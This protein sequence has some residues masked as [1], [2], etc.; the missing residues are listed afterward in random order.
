MV[1]RKKTAK[2][3][4]PKKLYFQDYGG[5]AY[6]YSSLQQAKNEARRTINQLDEVV[7]YEGKPILRLKLAVQEEKL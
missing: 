1:A 5:E 4:T 2:K 7:I 6:S 3:K